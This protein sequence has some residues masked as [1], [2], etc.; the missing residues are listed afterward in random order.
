M[1]IIAIFSTFKYFL[2][3]PDLDVLR[4]LLPNID[5]SIESDDLRL[6]AVARDLE[7]LVLVTVYV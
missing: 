3:F 1:Q 4:Q 5:K 7:G 2:W 6:Y